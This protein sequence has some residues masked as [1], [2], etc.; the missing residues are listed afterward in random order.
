MNGRIRSVVLGGSALALLCG[1]STAWGQMAAKTPKD[2]AVMQKVDKQIVTAVRPPCDGP[3]LSA[4]RPT[5]NK[6]IAS[7]KGILNISATIKNVGKQSFVS[8]PSQAAGEIVVRKVGVSGPSAYATVRTTPI[9]R[10][11]AGQSISL[12]GRYEIP[13]IIEWGER[14]ANPGECKAE[15]EVIV[16][17]SYD[18]DIRMDSNP[19][20][21]DCYSGNDRCA[22]VPSNFVK[23]MVQCP[24]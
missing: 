13:L 6:S 16:R 24:W 7:G 19:Q 8:S 9:S 20:N 3:D 11:N 10:L 15:V 17:V 12:S 1:L 22:E 23:Y 14:T 18:P 21:D 2:K 5:I 4:S